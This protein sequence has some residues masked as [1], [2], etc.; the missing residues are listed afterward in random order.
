MELLQCANLLA[1]EGTQ[2][3]FHSGNTSRVIKEVPRFASLYKFV[4]GTYKAASSNA[5]VDGYTQA[6]LVVFQ[7]SNVQSTL[8][9]RVFNVNTT[10]L[11]TLV[12][13]QCCTKTNDGSRQ[14]PLHVNVK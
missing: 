6:G 10:D 8:I 11:Y 12:A 7:T 13:K 1:S 14:D 5:L 9:N 4:D 2:Q 3:G